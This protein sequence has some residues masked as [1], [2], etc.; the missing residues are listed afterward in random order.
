VGGG[1]KGSAGTQIPGG[2]A[3]AGSEIQAKTV[4]T[5]SDNASTGVIIFMMV[6]LLRQA[7]SHASILPHFENG[8]CDM[9]H[10]PLI[11][12]VFQ[13]GIVDG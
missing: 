10:K 12:L 4:N 3:K 13:E 11:F 1:G 7:T 8:R 5:K 6:V 9:D 2:S